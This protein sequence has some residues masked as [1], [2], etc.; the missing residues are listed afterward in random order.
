MTRALLI[1]MLLLSAAPAAAQSSREAQLADLA[2]VRTE[3]LPKE[4]AYSAAARAAADRRLSALEARAG[5]LTPSELLVGLSEVGA[6]A[7]NAHSGLRYHD[8]LAVPDKR[9]PLRLLWFT[10]GLIVAR[11]SGEA[12]DL[13]G[14]R[15][16]TIEGLSPGALYERTRGLKGGK[17][18]DRKKYLPELIESEGV[19]HAMGLAKAPDALRL[20]LRLPNGRRVERRITMVPQAASPTAEFIRLWSPQPLAGETGWTAVKPASTPLYLQD[21]DQP[22]RLVDLPDR[23]AL[24]IQFRSN[25]DEDGHPIADFLKAADA[26]IAATRPR[27]LIID[28]RF[29][30]GGNLLTTLD[31]MRRLPAAATGRTFV[32]VGPHTYSAGIVSAAAVKK[33]GGE[34]VT[35]VGDELGDRLHFWSEGGLVRLPNSHLALRYTNGQFDLDKGC[36]GKPACLDD[37]VM[38]NFVSLEPRIRAPI[39]A[40]AWLAGRDPA[41]E[42]IS[43]ALAK[44]E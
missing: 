3:Y 32:L 11:A 14:A 26:R 34:R 31:F 30:V 2:L 8:P 21:P 22:F 6:L 43:V 13:A 35:V 16:L 1:A 9:L 36:A 18:V 28:L 12:G 42:A 41:M 10:D 20:S 27:H 7:D 29:D 5:A 33:G 39:T 44:P 24:Y 23:D 15:V 25:E 19:L 40:R 17:A 37:M 38:V 4:M